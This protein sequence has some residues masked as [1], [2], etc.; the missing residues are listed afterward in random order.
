[1]NYLSISNNSFSLSY[2]NNFLEYIDRSAK[3]T[4]TYIT[5]LRQFAA[6]LSYK[7]I[8]QPVR[9]DIIEYREY[10]SKPHYAIALDTEGRWQYRTDKSGN[11]IYITL[12]AS[13]VKAYLQ[14]VKQLFSWLASEGIYPN[15]A[16]NIHPPKIRADRHSKEALRPA[17]VKAIQDSIKANAENKRIT[18]ANRKKDTVASTERATEQGARLYAMY[19]L[20]VNCGL[21]TIEIHRANIGDIETVGGVSYIYIWGKGHS[22]ADTKKPLAREVKEAIDSYLSIRG[23]TSTNSPLFTATGNRSKGKRIAVTTIST[24]LKRAMQEA[25]YNSERLTA[26][27]LRHTAG[28]SVQELTNDIY[29]TQRYMRHASP[30]TTEIYLHN[31]TTRKEANIAEKLYK[32]YQGTTEPATTE[33][34]LQA[35]LEGLSEGQRKELAKLA[36]G[37]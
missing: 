32:Y 35:I 24:M 22:E 17:D 29:T 6:Y 26:H 16:E 14:S 31:D 13:T 33:N 10:L 30:A 2:I 7:Q 36:A 4:I 27:S 3:T 8:I 21:R 5:N 19:L 23:T 12:K 25:G 15:I 34:G 28:T 11:K 9:K 20:A 1:M 37:Y 18:A